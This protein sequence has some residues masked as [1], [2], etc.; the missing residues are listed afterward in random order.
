M[1]RV[2]PQ[3]PATTLLIYLKNKNVELL[4]HIWQQQYQYSAVI[5]IKRYI[6]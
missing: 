5:Y 4:T 1:L 6:A 2:H 3:M